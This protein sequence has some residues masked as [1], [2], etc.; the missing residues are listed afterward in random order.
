MVKT[1]SNRRMESC[2]CYCPVT[3]VIFDCD[4]T[5]LDTEHLYIK[6]I[7]ETL[8]PYGINYTQEDQAR[9]MARTARVLADTH[10][11]E[12][13]LP[14][15]AE[16]YLTAFKKAD[17]K[18]MKD[19]KLLPGVRDLIFHLHEHRIPLAIATSSNS[20]IIDVKFQSHA[21]IKSAF[22]HIVC[23]NDPELKTDRGKPEADIY[24]LAASRFHPPADPR[25]CLVFEDSPTGLKAGRAAGMQVVFI[26]ESETSRAR[27]EDPTMVLGS[28][29][30][31]QPEL[32]GLP[33]FPN[34]SK[35]EFG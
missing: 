23:G 22:H 17:Y 10:I 4:G 1:E 9:Y 12:F 34:C 28:M 20:E 31:F 7:K 2:R 11:K 21:D 13:N 32:F 19:V 33:A 16:Q 30:E 5:L 27:G 8:A 29:T 14:I 26:P 35:F 3:H 6:I 15:T 25:K 18:Y 24:L